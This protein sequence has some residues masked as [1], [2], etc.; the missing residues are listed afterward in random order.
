MGKKEEG[1]YDFLIF[2]IR[3]FDQG[4]TSVERL[5]QQQQ[6]GREGKRLI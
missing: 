6:E 4:K 2:Y 3:N 5:K 1:G